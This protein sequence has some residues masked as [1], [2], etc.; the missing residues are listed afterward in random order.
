M[1]P[2]IKTQCKEFRTHL[3]ANFEKLYIDFMNDVKIVKILVYVSSALFE[4]FT[5]SISYFKIIII[6]Y[7][8]LIFF[9]VEKYMAVENYLVK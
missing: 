3:I 5:L 4:V 2:P 1:R 8:K 7:N 9:V 6:L